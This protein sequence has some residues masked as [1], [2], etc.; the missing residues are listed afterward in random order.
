MRARTL[1][2][3][4]TALLLGGCKPSCGTPGTAPAA[5]SPTPQVGNPSVPVPDA[6]QALREA[7]A[8]LQAG[9][10]DEAISKGEAA[11]AAMPGNPVIWNVLGRA[12]AARFAQTRDAA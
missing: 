7:D 5:P 12:H 8:A 10:L 2:A 3:A 11:G 9:K 4:A 6:I 1:A